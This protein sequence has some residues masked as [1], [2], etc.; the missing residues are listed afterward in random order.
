MLAKH[1]TTS[2]I[3][4]FLT[5]MYIKSFMEITSKVCTMFSQL[6]VKV[7]ITI[8]GKS[9]GGGRWHL[10]ND[11]I[12]KRH[13]TKYQFVALKTLFHIMPPIT[14]G[15]GRCHMTPYFLVVKQKDYLHGTLLPKHN[16]WSCAL[17]FIKVHENWP[18]TPYA[19]SSTLVLQF[20]CNKDQ[21]C[22]QCHWEILW[23]L[24]Y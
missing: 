5:H 12:H 6:W 9:K 2:S 23:N 13:V 3:S 15:I 17:S 22:V 4:R 24:H 1:F 14:L 21:S 19:F 16:L 8:Q 10:P 7:V 18:K 11:K 20:L